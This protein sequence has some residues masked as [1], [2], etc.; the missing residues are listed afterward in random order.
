MDEKETLHSKLRAY[1]PTPPLGDVIPDV[2]R[3]VKIGDA[4]SI[5]PIR[6]LFNQRWQEDQS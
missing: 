5:E 4:S 6:E 2:E 1:V 3:L